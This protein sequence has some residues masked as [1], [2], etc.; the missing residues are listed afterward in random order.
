MKSWK[1]NA[2]SEFVCAEIQAERER[3]KT[4]SGWS[5]SHDDGHAEG[6]MALAAACYAAHDGLSGVPRQ[7]PWDERWWNPSTR[8]RNLIKAAALL[9][10]EIERVDRMRSKSGVDGGE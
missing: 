4:L 6:E 10:A 7:W 5:E 3:Q 1:G 2:K 8:R 9:V